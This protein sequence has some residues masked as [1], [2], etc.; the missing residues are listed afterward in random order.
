MPPSAEDLRNYELSLLNDLLEGC[1]IISFDWRYLFLNDAA[2][3]HARKTRQ[4]L[5]GQTMSEAYPGIDQTPM[6]HTLQKVM[7]DRQPRRMQNEFTYPDGGQGWFE[8][9]IQPCIEGIIIFSQDITASKLADDNTRQ[10]IKRLTTLRQIDLTILSNTDLTVI[11]DVVLDHVTTN[12]EVDAAMIL[13]F[14]P[15]TLHL[16]KHRARGF[17]SYSFQDFDIKMGA[18]ITGKIALERQPMAIPNLAH[19]A[20]FLRTSMVTREGFVS[21]FGAPLLARGEVLGVLELFHRSEC[22]PD[23]SWLNFFEIVAGQVA[24]AI[25]HVKTLGDLQRANLDL[26]LAYDHTIEGWAKTLE[27][28]DIETEGHSQRVTELTGRLAAR[29]GYRD[30]DLVHIRRG[31]LLHDIGKLGIPDAILFKPGPLEAAE[32]Q[33]MQSHP[34]IATDLL[35]QIPFLKNSVSIPLHHHEKWDGSG[36]PDGLKGE[37]IPEAARI[38]AIVDVWDALSSDRPYRKLWPRQKIIA[39][40]QEERGGHFDPRVL[41]AFID[42]IEE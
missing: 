34:R 24:I 1:Q 9:N 36:Y 29:L 38:F 12:L 20:R 10:E 14:D 5:L 2:L 28:R 37:A 13:L 33:V 7:E 42:L 30:A 23:S 4:E 35:A 39:H 19:E 11:S 27:L 40:L 8:L 26:L 18:G 41:D 31:A 3:E 16:R 15:H 21:Y 32:W 17:N 6:F 25:D 22:H